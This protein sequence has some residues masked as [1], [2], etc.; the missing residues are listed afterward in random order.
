MSH[1]STWLSGRRGSRSSCPTWPL[2]DWSDWPLDFLLIGH[3]AYIFPCSSDS[4]TDTWHTAS[5]KPSYEEIICPYPP[6]TVWKDFFVHFVLLVSSHQCYWC[7]GSYL[8]WGLVLPKMIFTISMDNTGSLSVLLHLLQFSGYLQNIFTIQSLFLKQNLNLIK[9]SNQYYYVV[10]IH[11][12]IF[13][14]SYFQYL[15]KQR[16]RVAAG[17]AS[18]WLRW[19]PCLGNECSTPPLLPLTTQLCRPPY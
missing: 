1:K 8:I 6:T 12:K 2:W 5:T 19:K 15:L 16:K 4:D 3:R 13:S 18:L 7:S 11:I 9:V 17:R 10:G 14:S